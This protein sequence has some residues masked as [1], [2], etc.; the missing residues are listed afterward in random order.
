MLDLSVVLSVIVETGLDKLVDATERREFVIRALKK[1]GL[2]PTHPPLDFDG[3]YA[4]SLV[5][6]GVGKPRPLIQF[7]RHEF[8]REA[9]RHAYYQPDQSD[10]EQEGRDFIEWNE[11]GKEIAALD[12]DLKREITYFATIFETLVELSRQ[13]SDAKL[14]MQLGVMASDLHVQIEELAKKLEQRSSWED[15]QSE[16][17]RTSKAMQTRLES[18]VQQIDNLRLQSDNSPLEA[19]SNMIGKPSDNRR[20]T[21]VSGTTVTISGGIIYNDSEDCT[22]TV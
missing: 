8:I 18:L 3:L 17:L 13:P 5:E 11:I 2:D 19:R 15:L 10:F 7:F 14:H 6:Y 22:P 12:I 1:L 16:L 21:F 4:Y 20:G 9:F